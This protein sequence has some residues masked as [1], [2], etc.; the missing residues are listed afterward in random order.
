MQLGALQLALQVAHDRVFGLA[1]GVDVGQ[2]RVDGGFLED[3]QHVVVF[4][5]FIAVGA[6]ADVHQE[7]ALLALD[8]DLARRHRAI[9]LL[10]LKQGGADI[11]A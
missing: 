7:G 3:H 8:A 6:G 5:R 2:Q 1:D 9:R 11:E 10:D 4:G